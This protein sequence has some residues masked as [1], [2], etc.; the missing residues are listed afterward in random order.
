MKLSL[1]TFYK[2][3]FRL[4]KEKDDIRS[5]CA[6]LYFF[7][8]TVNSHNLET[9]N[10]IPHVILLLHSAMKTHLLTNQNARKI[11]IIT[12]ISPEN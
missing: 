7:H 9:A 4:N 12:V 5:V 1:T 2:I 8:E 10:H 11:Q 3:I 6:K